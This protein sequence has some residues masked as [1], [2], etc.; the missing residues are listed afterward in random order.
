MSRFGTLRPLWVRI[1]PPSR[2]HSVTPLK[3]LLLAAAAF[4]LS[5]AA[6]GDLLRI[7]AP[8][9][10]RPTVSIPSPLTSP[11]YPYTPTAADAIFADALRASSPAE[12]DFSLDIEPNTVVRDESRTLASALLGLTLYMP[13]PSAVAMLGLGMAFLIV[14]KRSKR[15]LR[16]Q[17]HLSE[18]RR[19]VKTEH[20]MMAA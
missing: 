18:L 17:R 4:A 14:G 20:R 12:A 10:A 16:R 1:F 8:N 6:Q 2:T 15:S 11:E 5:P 13:E 7:P 3:L 19:R 9:P